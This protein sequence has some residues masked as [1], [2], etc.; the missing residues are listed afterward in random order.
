MIALPSLPALRAF[1]MVARESSFVRAAAQLNVT[2]SAVSHQIRQLEEQ[3]GTPLL[4]RAR[5]GSGHSRTVPTAAG[6]ELLIAVEDTL[7]HLAEAC[8]SIR[9]RAAQRR[10][11]LVV[12]ANGSFA[13]LWL[14]PRLAAFAALHPSV[15]WHMRAVEVEALDMAEHGIHLAILRARP[16]AIV[17]PDQLLFEETV[18]PVCSPHLGFAGDPDALLRQ[19]LLEEEHHK[20][21]PE[22]G[23][24]TWLA[25]LGQP[26]AGARI[27]RFSSFN[28]V[29]G[30]AVAGAGIA[31]GRSPMVEAEL[32]AGRLVRLFAPL[33]LPCAMA[34]T[35]RVNP[36]VRRDPHVTQLRDFLLSG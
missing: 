6:Q 22:K 23:W 21:S 11:S 9:E 2:T 12:S 3:L 19:N 34:F 26:T 4:V 33:A 14:A 24:K 36:E 17:P 29:I 30:A 32:A 8:G 27:V 5:N 28:Q 1:A 18:F 35:L 13:S 25:L 10:S 15:S 31:L 7:A 20:L 16:D